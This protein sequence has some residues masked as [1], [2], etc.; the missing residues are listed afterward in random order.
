MIGKQNWFTSNS[1]LFRYTPG[2]ENNDTTNTQKGLL[3]DYAFERL[4]F[5]GE[6]FSYRFSLH[7]L[8]LLHLNILFLLCTVTELCFL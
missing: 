3:F 2:E 8:S 1:H 7:P 5:G 4:F 6:L